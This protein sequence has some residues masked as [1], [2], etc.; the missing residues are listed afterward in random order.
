MKRSKRLFRSI[1]KKLNSKVEHPTSEQPKAESERNPANPEPNRIPPITRTIVEISD[2]T[3]EEYRTNQKQQYRENKINRGIA[4]AA[5]LGAWLY[6]AIAAFQ[7]AAMLNSNNLTKI[8]TENAAHAFRMSERAW[9]GFKYQHPI[10]V[11]GREVAIVSSVYV[12]AGKSPAT[13]VKTMIRLRVGDRIPTNQGTL[14]VTGPVLP[15]CADDKIPL[16]QAEGVLIIPNVEHMATVIPES[17]VTNR[18]ADIVSN[19]PGLYL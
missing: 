8:A 5:V 11:N 15:A 12:N 1:Q 4:I 14:D 2:S 10:L 3:L 19:R 18:V 7:W 17:E 9:I 6:A 16:P 13:H